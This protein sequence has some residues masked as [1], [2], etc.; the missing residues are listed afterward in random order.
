MLGLVVM[1]VLA[2]VGVLLRLSF[3]EIAVLLAVGTVLLAIETMNT[4]VEMLCDRLVPQRDEAIGK[5]KD[6][7]AGATAVMEIGGAIVL[8][9]LIAP[10]VWRLIRS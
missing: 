3:V 5:V 2:V 7:A 8:L 10:H 6:V 9:T 4:A 1:S